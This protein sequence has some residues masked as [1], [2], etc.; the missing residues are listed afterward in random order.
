MPTILAVD[1]NSLGHRAFHALV[2]EDPGGPLVTRG[3]VGML[4]TAWT[5]G[6]FD[7]IVVA[8]DHPVN[9]RKVD[10]PAYKGN[11][12]DTDPRLREGL[13]DLRVH[14][15][16]CGF[17]VAEEEGAEADDL[18]AA[19][20]DDCTRRGW[21]CTVLSSD[22]DLTTLV[23]EHVTLLRPRASMADLLVYD[24]VSVV[25]EYGVRP[26]QY[27]DLA[28]LR[29]DPSDGLA[30]VHGIGPKIAARLLRDYDDI[31]GIYAAL[32]NLPP[33][34]EAALRAGRD[35]VERNL[36]LMSPIP[37]LTVDV[38]GAVARGIDGDTVYAALKPLGLGAV[39]GRFKNVVERPPLPPM[40]PPPS[41]ELVEVG[42]VD[43]QRA[44]SRPILRDHVLSVREA[45]QAALF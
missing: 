44:P 24:P 13:V 41:E 32:C 1:G 11:R 38:D 33:K 43:H 28:A 8:F 20:A 23:N 3:V 45:E 2:R 37:N 27:T 18:L 40:P 15:D 17:T 42:A 4:A 39:G 5:R 16:D 25:A 12:D 10:D 31:P 7:A 26:D 29:G 34:I 30:G 35:V 9:R 14:L 21:P 22:R 36:W 6:P 19:V